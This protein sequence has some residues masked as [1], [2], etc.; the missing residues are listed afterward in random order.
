MLEQLK[1]DLRNLKAKQR[2]CDFVDRSIALQKEIDE[3]KKLIE[4]EKIKETPLTTFNDLL[5]FIRQEISFLI[6]KENH[7]GSPENVAR[8][9]QIFN[10]AKALFIVDDAFF[11]ER[12]K[13]DNIELL[14][15]IA[16]TAIDLRAHLQKASIKSLAR[17]NNLKK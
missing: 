16:I 10:S 3:V 5:L 11:Q 12:T 17:K 14:E 7:W 15:A 2:R 1:K 9:I 8:E 6:H 4:L 13:F